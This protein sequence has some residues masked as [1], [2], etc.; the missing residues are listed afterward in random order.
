[1]FWLDTTMQAT[2]FDASNFCYRISQP[3]ADIGNILYPER[4]YQM[5]YIEQN[6]ILQNLSEQDICFDSNLKTLIDRERVLGR[7]AMDLFDQR[8]CKGQM[9]SISTMIF[10]WHGTSLISC[11]NSQ[12][13]LC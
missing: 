5:I 4:F 10:H 12:H 1:M 11:Q 2:V 9:P 3:L 8:N 6:A 7:H 13:K